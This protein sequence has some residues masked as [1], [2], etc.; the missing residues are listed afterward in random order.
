MN[1]WTPGQPVVSNQVIE[2][3]RGNP[4][5]YV[6]TSLAGDFADGTS[7]FVEFFSA[8][9]QSLGRV[10]GDVVE[11]RIFFEGSVGFADSMKRGV[12][13][14]LHVDEDGESRVRSQ[15]TVIRCEAPFPD[16]PATQPNVVGATYE[17]S[18]GTPGVLN[19]PAWKILQ[20]RPRVYD[21]SS[22]SL[23]NAVAAGSLFGGLAPWDKVA[24][25]W[26]APLQ[27]DSVKL[28]YNTIRGGL[29]PEGL[30][31]GEL[32]VVLCSNSSMTEWAGFKHKQVFG[33]GSWDKDTIS[34]VTGSGPTTMV[35]RATVSEDTYTNQQF[36]AEYSHITNTF[37]LWLDGVED[38][39]VEWT[40]SSSV[41]NHGEG[42]R[43]VGFGFKSEALFPG[44]GVSD[45]SIR[46]MG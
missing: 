38:P 32:W 16:A 8:R 24:M 12:A 2:L 23:P 31:N 6:Y 14:R 4:F 44:V 20:G 15:G 42:W 27:T 9:G 46:D 21:Y 34:V 45:W 26:Y 33:I 28:S 13:W 41:V 10:D 35:N 18:F 11:N 37:T 43:Y 3:N 25:R 30:W 29:G 17:Y 22:R 19:D 1:L 40:D 7:A 39:I 5:R 36:T